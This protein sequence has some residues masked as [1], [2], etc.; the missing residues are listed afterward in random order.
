MRIG[1]AN[2]IKVNILPL[3]IHIR[4]MC[5]IHQ[6]IHQIR[7]TLLLGVK[8]PLKKG[9]SQKT[10]SSNIK[11]EM[12]TKPQKQAVAIALNMAKKPS[13]KIPKR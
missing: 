9:K 7:S 2:V 4:G 1:E 10:I 13:A 5:Y 3:H 11:T 6:L 8:M 12:K